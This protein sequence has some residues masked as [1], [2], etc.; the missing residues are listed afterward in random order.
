IFLI[1]LII[2]HLITARVSDSIL[3]SRVG[4]ID[5]ILGFL[6]GAARGFILIVIP[7]MLYDAFMVDPKKPENTWPWVQKSQSLPYIQSTGNSIKTILIRIIPSSLT[8]PSG[9][10]GEQQG[11]IMPKG[12]LHEGV[13]HPV[14][15]HISV[16]WRS[17]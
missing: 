13:A 1:V 4:M 5:R 3:D 11:F 10:A 9:G 15:F 14:A 16:T 17:C 12:E 7:Y 2:V 6:F 8:T